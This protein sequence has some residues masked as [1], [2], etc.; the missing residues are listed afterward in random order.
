MKNLLKKISIIALMMFVSFS[1]CA[2]G[3]TN[4]ED[5]KEPAEKISLA[6]VMISDVEFENSKSTEIK[7]E[8]SKYTVSGT[9][10]SM[11]KS[12]KI[13]FGSDEVTH[14]VAIKFAFDKERT[15]SAFEIRGEI[16]KVYSDDKNVKN[17]VGKL[18][19]LLDSEEGEDAYCNL[20]LS[21]NTKKY[22]LKSTYSDGTE[23]SIE[24]EIVATLATAKAE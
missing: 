12:Q 17:Y 3:K 6:K 13:V 7:H 15:I 4:G 9:I 1:L 22:T 21:A 16:T 5:G 14:V 23:S 19:E 18:S 20:V 11:S 2:C 8:G 10:D 24:L